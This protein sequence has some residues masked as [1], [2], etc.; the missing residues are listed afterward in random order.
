MYTLFERRL[1]AALFEDLVR[2]EWWIRDDGQ[3]ESAEM[4]AHEVIAFEA[5]M[6]HEGVDLDSLP[7]NIADEYGELRWHYQWTPEQITG[8]RNM[9][10]DEDVINYFKDGRAD[11]REYV[12]NKWDWI[13][14]AFDNFQTR[15]F[16]DNVKKR[17]GDFLY[18]EHGFGDEQPVRPSD[19]I[20]I[21]EI[22]AS[23]LKYR[24]AAYPTVRIIEAE[25]SKILNPHISAAQIKGL[26]PK[27]ISGP[28]AFRM[29]GGGPATL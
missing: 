24:Y 22:K 17:I 11:P 29:A 8:L 18:E 21:E 5:I 7:A 20:I 15:E 26:R 23:G 3:W 27:E 19:T 28:E 13:R 16:T 1:D 4:T 10:V 2:G 25:I 9:G 12:I 14:V 6:G